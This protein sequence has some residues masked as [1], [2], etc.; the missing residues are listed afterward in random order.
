[1]KT[2]THRATATD[3]LSIYS[4]I[5]MRLRSGPYE[6]RQLQTFFHNVPALL[7]Q[8]QRMLEAGDI[9]ATDLKNG[10]ITDRSLISLS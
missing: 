5:V 6:Y 7:I 3:D 4:S 10:L 2:E 9:A 8:L 1:M